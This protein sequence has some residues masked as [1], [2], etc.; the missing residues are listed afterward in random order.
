MQKGRIATYVMFFLDLVLFGMILPEMN[1]L[2]SFLAIFGYSILK[3]IIGLLPI[4]AIFTPILSSIVFSIMIINKYGAVGWVT[5]CVSIAL[6]IYIMICGIR[7]SKY[8]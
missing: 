1:I 3:V 7:Q 8:L 6:N 2:L 4:G 5:L